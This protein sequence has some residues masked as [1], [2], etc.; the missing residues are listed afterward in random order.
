MFL[1]KNNK[2]KAYKEGSFH[3][4]P[5]E[6][7]LIIGNYWMECEKFTA[8]LHQTK[9][10]PCGDIYGTPPLASFSCLKKS[11]VT[12]NLSKFQQ[13][14]LPSNCEKHVNERSQ[15]KEQSASKKKGTDGLTWTR[16]T[17]IEIV[18]FW[19]LVRFQFFKVY[20]VVCNVW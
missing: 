4:K 12:N 9:I 6:W 14:Q 3:P 2:I 7:C 8:V 11:C 1:S 15:H 10:V 5:W 20:F 18:F 17:Q 16:L 13:W 19:K